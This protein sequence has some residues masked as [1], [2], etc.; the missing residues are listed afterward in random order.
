MS[1]DVKK[2]QLS[3]N[4]VD[5][6]VDTSFTIPAQ[7]GSDTLCTIHFVKHLMSLY[8]D[9]KDGVFKGKV[10]LDKEIVASVTLTRAH[11]EELSDI[12]KNQLRAFDEQ[13]SNS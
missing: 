9:S 10:S 12:I 3:D 5:C 11:A 4:H 7:M 13:Q 8:E 2:M 1:E 6:F